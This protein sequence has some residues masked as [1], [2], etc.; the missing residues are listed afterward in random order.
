MIYQEKVNG[1]AQNITKKGNSPRDSAVK[2]PCRFKE[3]KGLCKLSTG[4]KGVSG[5]K[6]GQKEP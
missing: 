5:K 6:Q 3:I 2:E 1:W 4:S